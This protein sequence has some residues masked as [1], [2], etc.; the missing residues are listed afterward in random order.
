MNAKRITSIILFLIW[1]ISI[2]EYS[3]EALAMDNTNVTK[4]KDGQIS[5]DTSGYPVIG[6]LKKRDKVITIQKG[7]DG[8]LYT[9]ETKDG[10]ILGVDL[11][12]DILYAE[13]PDLKSLIEKGMAVEDAA[14][15][16]EKSS[17]KSI[18]IHK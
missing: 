6:H 11:P 3:G 7:P 10:K 16:Q 15:R 5:E 4:I 13:F 12:A 14:Y 2:A 1:S 8:P 17:V 18:D 9:V